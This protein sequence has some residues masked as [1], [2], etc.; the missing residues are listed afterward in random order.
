MELEVGHG[1][2]ESLR[3]S[4]SL[5]LEI[6]RLKPEVSQLKTERDKVRFHCEAPGDLGVDW[7]CAELVSRVLASILASTTAQSA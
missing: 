3:G 5:L 1:G 7:M 4:S 6:A 2:N